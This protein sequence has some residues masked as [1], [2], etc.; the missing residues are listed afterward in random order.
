MVCRYWNPRETSNYFCSY[1]QR[2]KKKQSTRKSD[3]RWCPLVPAGARWCP[4]FYC[5]IP[6]THN[7]TKPPPDDDD[8]GS[9]RQR[10]ALLGGLGDREDSPPDV[11][12]CTPRTARFAKKLGGDLRGD[13][14][15]QRRR[16]NTPPRHQ[17]S[18]VAVK[19][20]TP[21]T[22]ELRPRHRAEHK[23]RKR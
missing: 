2:T 6:H 14:H 15:N 12:R 19:N 11:V 17:L 18:G 7:E 21:A 13:Q 16:K 23:Q 1:L 10:I 22:R 5:T 20:S 3:A 9:H 8:N 4:S